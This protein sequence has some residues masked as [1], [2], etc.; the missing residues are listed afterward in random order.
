MTRA[1]RIRIAEV[2]AIAG[3]VGTVGL[4]VYLVPYEREELSLFGW[5]VTMLLGL[6]LV[7]GNLLLAGSQFIAR[8]LALIC[9]IAY[10]AWGL[11]TTL[12]YFTRW[13]TPLILEEVIL[14]TGGVA[15]AVVWVAM[16]LGQR[17]HRRKLNERR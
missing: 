11:L 16:F 10:A 12:D 6:G 1:G 15:F 4:L 7:V 8:R 3:F 13:Q 9:A 17:Q 2:V 14:T 5:A